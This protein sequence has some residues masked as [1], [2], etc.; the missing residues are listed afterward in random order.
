MNLPDVTAGTEAVSS[1]AR[2]ITVAG[3]V[4]ETVR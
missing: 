1:I 2:T 4:S 3:S